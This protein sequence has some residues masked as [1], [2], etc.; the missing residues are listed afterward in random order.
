MLHGK[1]KKKKVVMVRAYSRY[2]ELNL[3]QRITIES[4]HDSLDSINDFV[5]TLSGNSRL[6]LI[7]QFWFLLTV[8]GFRSYV[9]I[10]SIRLFCVRCL[11]DV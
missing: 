9:S 4:K 2:T 5:N 6:F 1:L 10:L 7:V 3:I 11:A 8:L